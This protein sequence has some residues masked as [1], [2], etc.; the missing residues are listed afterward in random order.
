MIRKMVCI[1]FPQLSVQRHLF[2]T[3]LPD[4]RG[5]AIVAVY[6]KIGT[7]KPWIRGC[8]PAAHAIGISTA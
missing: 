8:S 1:W 6:Q 7:Q 4:Q 5:Q 2:E 3:V